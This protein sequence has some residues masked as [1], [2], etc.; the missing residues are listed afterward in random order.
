MG[1][2]GLL[3]LASSVDA[4]VHQ[5][6]PPRVCPVMGSAL[7]PSIPEMDYLGLRVGFCCPGCD[8][9]FEADP[10]GVLAEAAER[11]WI[12]AISRFD[13]VSGLRASVESGVPVV[14]YEGVRYP[15]QTDENREAFLANPD[16]F[17]ALPEMASLTCP[18]MGVEMVNFQQAAGYVDWNNT[19]FA[20]CCE[21][22]DTAFLE[23][24]ERF[25][26]SV[27]LEPATVIT[28]PSA[29]ATEAVDPMAAPAAGRT[30]LMP[31]C[32]GCAG[33]ARMLRDGGLP[34][35]WTMNYRFIAIGDEQSRHRL[36]LDYTV[37]PRLSIGLETAFSGDHSHPQPSFGS[38]P[39]R[40]LGNSTGTAPVLP[41][42]TWFVTPETEF[43]P[44]VVLGFTADRLSTPIGQAFFA[45]FSK[46]FPEA[47]VAPFVSVKYNTHD[48]SVAF[49]FG[50]NVSLTDRL[51]FQAINDG[52]YT[53]LLLTFLGD[54][55]SPSLILARTRY[56]GIAVTIGF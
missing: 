2:A 47:R 43:T 22:C 16:R 9:K 56:P 17:T 37:T 39:L 28:L 20:I 19:R 55:V 53:H 44:S 34:Y 51:T 15:F 29:E 18:V 42:A 6:L 5:D 36:T 27:T 12:V 23:N 14:D 3:A 48:R 50:A 40:Y 8:D 31:T 10:K 38:N 49:P 26:A 45:T 35:E 46:A 13:P 41:R 21:G 25:A 24:P 4:S 30:A 33:E 52:D 7:S 54:Q 32:A 1:V 11:G